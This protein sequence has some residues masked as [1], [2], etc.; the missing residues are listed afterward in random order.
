MCIRDRIPYGPP[1]AP[2]VSSYGYANNVTLS[3]DAGSSGNG[4][5]ITEVEIQTTDGGVQAGQAISGSV[6]QGNGRNLSKSIR[7]HA[8]DSTG[9]WGAW[10]S[11]STGVTW[12][13]PTTTWTRSG[14]TYTPCPWTS[15]E[16]VN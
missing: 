1:N 15:C 14:V 7:A 11:W 2:Q 16:K 13:D 4:R 6:V 5:P 9:L 12:G 8:K 10:S 3:W